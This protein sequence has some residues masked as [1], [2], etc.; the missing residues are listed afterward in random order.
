MRVV[1]L[2][3]LL[4]L[5]SGGQVLAQPYGDYY[6]REFLWGISWNLGI[7]TGDTADYTKS[8]LSGRGLGL[9]GRKFIKPN[10]TLG[11]SFSWNVLNAQK[12]NTIQTEDN[13]TISGNQRTYLNIFPLLVNAHYYLGYYGDLRPYFGLNAGAYIIENR[14][15]IG[16]Y[17]TQ[18]TNWHFGVAPEI[19]VLLPAGR[20]LGFFNVRYNWTTD[21]GMTPEVTYWGFNLGLGLQ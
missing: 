8:Y 14:L 7:P 19:G 2:A 17:S 11:A 20:F 12:F 21:S 4:V 1:L 9:E 6:P 10:W 18:E 13:L 5:V 3:L 15:E 16:L